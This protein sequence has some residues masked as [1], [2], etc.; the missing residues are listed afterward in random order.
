MPRSVTILG[1]GLLVSKKGVVDIEQAMGG[2]RQPHVGHHW[3]SGKPPLS[4]R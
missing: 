3:R 1:Q 2:G 4:S